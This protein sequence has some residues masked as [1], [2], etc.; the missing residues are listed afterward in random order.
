MGLDSVTPSPPPLTATFD[1][2][3]PTLLWQPPGQAKLNASQLLVFSEL[4]SSS[5]LSVQLPGT[6]LGMDEP[7]PLRGVLAAGELLLAGDGVADA[8]LD[9]LDSAAGV[10]ELGD[11]LGRQ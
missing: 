1:G 4:N 2:E 8:L 9:G 5:N 11:G 10:D 6:P 7:L 3:S